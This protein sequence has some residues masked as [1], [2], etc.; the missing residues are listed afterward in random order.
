V[1]NSQPWQ[2]HVRESQIRLHA[3][4]QRK[5]HILDRHGRQLTIS[6]GCAL[7]NV[8]TSLA[9]DGIP[10]LVDRFPDRLQPDLVAVVE[11]SPVPDVRDGNRGLLDKYLDRRHTNRR[12][13]TSEA[14]PPGLRDELRALAADDG[15]QLL[16]AS[17][18]RGRE[19]VGGAVAR[20]SQIIDL[21]PAYRV[22]WR[23]WREVSGE[24]LGA[25]IDEFG[26][27]T[28]WPVVLC[29]DADEPADWLRVGEVLQ[30][31]LLELARHGYTAKLCSHV[32]EVPAAR[33]TL[34]HELD[35][36]G[37]PQV[38]LSAGRST[39]PS[40]GS[41]RRRLLEVITEGDG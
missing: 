41:R 37:F 29:T 28:G 17:T 20:A 27:V 7:F 31:V 24:D 14:L 33:T 5:L 4:L 25:D 35:L 30:H 15:V 3:D 39:E 2:L 1:H 8:R 19:V 40:P 13:F 36:D 23:A 18:D 9:A 6:C 10:V 32:I 38:L 26:A 21:D 22:E 11:L 12:G 16:S 34:R